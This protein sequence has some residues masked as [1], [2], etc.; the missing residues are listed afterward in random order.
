VAR[1]ARAAVAGL[2][3]TTTPIE[4]LQA[5]LESVALRLGLIYERLAPLA[6]PAHEVVASGGA[7]VR[8]RVWAQMI[9]T[10]SAGRSRSTARAKLRAAARRSSPS[11]RSGSHPPRRRAEGGAS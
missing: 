7:L 11:T 2:S 8:S 6:A 3:L 10:R 1:A 5:A 4:I 9:A